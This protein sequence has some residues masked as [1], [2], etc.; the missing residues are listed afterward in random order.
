MYYVQPTKILHK[1]KFLEATVL[2]WELKKH[3]FKT[4]PQSHTK[5]CGSTST[6]C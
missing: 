3:T 5:G 2:M 6:S 1:H 4:S